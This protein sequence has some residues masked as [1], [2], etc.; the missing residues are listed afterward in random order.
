MKKTL[1][2]L[3]CLLLITATTFA[4]AK[5]AYMVID[6]KGA[7]IDSALT[8]LLLDKDIYQG[9]LIT[10]ANVLYPKFGLNS[11]KVTFFECAPWFDDSETYLFLDTDLMHKKDMSFFFQPTKTDREMRKAMM[12]LNGKYYTNPQAMTISGRFVEHQLYGG[13]ILFLFMVDSFEVAGKKYTG[14]IPDKVTDK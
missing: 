10:L 13:L 3:T 8:D 9:K 7:N 2:V 12:D 1:L 6:G 11:R 4:Q 5:G 14:A